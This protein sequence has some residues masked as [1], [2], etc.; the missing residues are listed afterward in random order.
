M[1]QGLNSIGHEVSDSGL[2]VVVLSVRRLPGD[3]PRPNWCWAVARIRF[4]CTDKYH[5]NIDYYRCFVRTKRYGIEQMVPLYEHPKSYTANDFLLWDTI[6]K[7]RG[8]V[9]EGDICFEA[10]ISDP[11]TSLIMLSGV[12]DTAEWKI[13]RL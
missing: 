6:L 8:A 9:A 4:T 5:H 11:E 1:A 7:K 2:H 12:G 10:P 3:N 13:G